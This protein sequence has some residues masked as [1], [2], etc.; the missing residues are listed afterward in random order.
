MPRVTDGGRTYTFAIRPGFRFSPP[1]NEA[2]T[3]ATFKYSME[4]ALSPKTRDYVRDTG[5]VDAIVGAKRYE[6][7]KA[8]Q[9]SGIVAHGNTLTIRLEKPLP[10][11]PAKLAMAW[12]CAVPIG[13]PTD[14]SGLPILPAAGPYYVASHTPG[15]QLVLKRNPNYHG[16]RPHHLAEIDIALDV[17]PSRSMA[18]VE[19]GS[20]DYNFGDVVDPAT[21]PTRLRKL[22]GPGSPASKKG[23]QRWF[24]N[25]TLNISWMFLNTSRPLFASV[26]MRQAFNFAIDRTALAK[27]NSPPAIP[28]DHYLPP[29]MPGYRAEHVYPLHPDLA[30]ARQ[31][32]GPGKHG[33]AILYTNNSP[34]GKERAQIA[35]QAL[36]AIGI[37]AQ[38]QYFPIVAYFGKIAMKGEPFDIGVSGGWAIDYLDPSGM[39]V[40]FDGRLPF[41]QSADFS[42]FNSSTVNARLD[43]ASKLTGTARYRALGRLDVDLARHAAPVAAWGVFTNGELFSA[44]IGCQVFQPIY[45]ATDLAAMCIRP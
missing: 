16:P 44:R 30:R 8:T 34:T 25:P 11:L 13:T 39:L 31:L 6:E 3:A 9:I 36:E 42:R 41:P 2:V 7:G 19:S 18:D 45:G 1:S 40:S 24:E 29:G 27:L 5:Y 22:Y 43:A 15:E 23:H 28:T 17:A 14:P 4:R 10:D 20:A 33:T 26:R 32:A 12:A 35:K 38:I 21:D 37:D